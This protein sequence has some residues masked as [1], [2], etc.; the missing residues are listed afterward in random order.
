MRPDASLPIDEPSVDVVT[1]HARTS[2]L[3]EGVVSCDS[4]DLILVSAHTTTRVFVDVDSLL[5]TPEWSKVASGNTNHTQDSGHQQDPEVLKHRKDKTTEHHQHRAA[6]Q[7]LASSHAVRN[8]REE[9]AEKDIAQ[10]RKSHKQPDTMIGEVEG[11]EEDCCILM[12]VVD[13]LKQSMRA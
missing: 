5:N 13:P 9:S 11:G 2:D 6:H 3:V 7:D 12:S 8:E 4:T 10:Q 1:Y